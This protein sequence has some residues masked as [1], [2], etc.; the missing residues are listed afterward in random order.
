[1][2]SRNWILRKIYK[3]RFH[4]NIFVA[5]AYKKIRPPYI[6]RLLCIFN[7]QNKLSFILSQDHTQLKKKT[8]QNL[9]RS[10]KMIFILF[11]NLPPIFYSAFETIK[12]KSWNYLSWQNWNLLN[13]KYTF[14]KT[15]ANLLIFLFKL[16]VVVFTSNTTDM[17]ANILGLNMIWNGNKTI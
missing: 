12:N 9:A 8:K 10:A 13:W 6:K 3:I 1:M 14:K 15:K 17:V 2:I 5:N 11:E 4:F 16:R 7:G